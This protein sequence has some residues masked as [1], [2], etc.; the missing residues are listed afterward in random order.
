[1]KKL[2]LPLALAALLCVSLTSWKQNRSVGTLTGLEYEHLTVGTQH[3]ELCDYAPYTA[4]HRGRSLGRIQGGDNCCHLYAV[5]GTDQYVYCC[6]DQGGR[7][8]RAVDAC[9]SHHHAPDHSHH[10]RGHGCCRSSRRF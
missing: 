9:S 1:M 7:M 6:W 3:Y 4:A 5:Q 2:W 10:Q 8:Y